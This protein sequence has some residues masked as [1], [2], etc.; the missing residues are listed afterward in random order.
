MSKTTFFSILAI[1]AIIGGGAF[2][3]QTVLAEDG[4][5]GLFGQGRHQEGIEQRGGK[6]KMTDELRDQMKQAKFENQAEFLGMT[7]D[8]LQ[9]ALKGKTL[10]ELLEENGK[11]EEAIQEWREKMQQERQDNMV[12]KWEE[13]GLTDD[14]IAGRLEKMQERQENMSKSRSEAGGEV[15]F[16]SKAFGGQR[17][18]N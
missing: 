1:A 14:Q 13:H 16:G 15:P 10:H 17:N 12:E 6:M 3:T 9:E 2:L 4:G 11:T 7:V 8:E 5:S 18:N